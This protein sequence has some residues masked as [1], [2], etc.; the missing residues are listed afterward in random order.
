MNY[1][2]Y[3]QTQHDDILHAWNTGE[4]NIALQSPTGSGKT[5][6]FSG[7]TRELN[8]PTVAIAHRQELVTQMSR[9]FARHGV[10]HSVVGPATLIRNIN[11]AHMIE[12]G[13][14]YYRTRANLR[15]ASIDTLV[16]A[17]QYQ[18]AQDWG[19]E[20]K[21]WIMD[22][23]HH[24][25]KANKW[26][27]GVDLF[28]NARGLGVSAW[29]GRTDGKGLGSCADGYYNVLLH[30]PTPQY[31]IERGYL[32]PFKLYG[33]PSDITTDGIDVSKVTGE[34]NKH[35]LS[36][37]VKASKKI[38]GDVVE[39]YLKLARG[40]IGV[41]FVDN[42]ETARI[43]AE[44]FC[45][46][47]VP[48]VAIDANTPDAD[49]IKALKKLERG[50]LLQIVNVDIFGEGFDCPAIEVVS[51]ARPTASYSLYIQQFG[52][53]LRLLEGKLYAIIIDHVGNIVRHGGPPLVMK[54]TTLERRDDKTE[55]I[56]DPDT[57]GTKL[58]TQCLG[59]YES[60]LRI[61]PYC[62]FEYL[63]IERSVPEHVEGNLVLLDFDECRRLLALAEDSVKPPRSHGNEMIDARNMRLYNEKLALKNDLRD[64]IA[65]W[66]G[67]QITKNIDLQ[68]RYRLFYKTFG[69]D[70]LTA[71][72]LDKNKTEELLNAVNRECN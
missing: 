67:I 59:R 35:Q 1:R 49:R 8:I 11:K 26:G 12:F 33:R 43:I 31:L 69:V 65:L 54:P 37:R 21:L 18:L 58:C 48:A 25:L 50:E 4:K 68:D 64:N 30:G 47:G 6:L 28:P 13:K 53:A 2:D 27:K 22:E 70:V 17:K 71:L 29:F 44:K 45:A 23:G 46:A 5:V 40:K 60:Y 41:T 15:I 72:T 34:F 14:T 57:I 51:F 66:S 61:C 20:V 7:I 56:V 9:T 36:T 55:T 63:P 16:G 62:G 52:R 24:L 10:E 42:T 38:T 3:Q 39:H 19:K 32:T